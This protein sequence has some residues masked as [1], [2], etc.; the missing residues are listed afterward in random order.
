MALNKL[1][2]KSKSL[3]KIIEQEEQRAADFNDRERL[4]DN[5]NT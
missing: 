5:Q 3:N 1:R 4:L 2:K